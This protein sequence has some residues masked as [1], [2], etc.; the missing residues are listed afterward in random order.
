MSATKPAGVKKVPVRS[1]GPFAPPKKEGKTDGTTEEREKKHHLIKYGWR[2]YIRYCIYA[3]VL[4][5]TFVT[6]LFFFWYLMDIAVFWVL[7]RIADFLGYLG[8]ALGVRATNRDMVIVASVIVF[9]VLIIIVT[10]NIIA[11]QI[12]HGDTLF[13]D[14]VLVKREAGMFSVLQLTPSGL[15][16]LLYVDLVFS[17]IDLP[18]IAVSIYYAVML[19]TTTRRGW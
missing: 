14:G 18:L 4:L 17:L 11:L 1:V 2:R 16:S 5:R 12:V 13:G 15:S 6:C 9:I 8:I 19:P 10:F 7:V 3:V